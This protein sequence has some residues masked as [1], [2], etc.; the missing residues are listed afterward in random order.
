MFSNIYFYD[1]ND[2]I[3]TTLLE[4]NVDILVDYIPETKMYE[5]LNIMNDLNLFKNKLIG[6]D[7]CFYFGYNTLIKE[8]INKNNVNYLIENTMKKNSLID[9]YYMKYLSQYEKK[10]FEILLNLYENIKKLHNKI[11]NDYKIAQKKKYELDVVNKALV[12]YFES[13]IKHIINDYFLKIKLFYILSIILS[14]KNEKYILIFNKT[15]QQ[16]IKSLLG[17]QP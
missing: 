7:I 10:H 3:D 13:N 4:D 6:T 5:T 15:L 17:I 8:F 11:D 16:Q 14:P 1:L 9:E 2:T 12:E